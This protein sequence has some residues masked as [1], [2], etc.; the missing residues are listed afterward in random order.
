MFHSF[1]TLSRILG[2]GAWCHHV[3]KIQEKAFGEKRLLGEKVASL[4]DTF[5]QGEPT[6]SLSSG[7]FNR[8]D[9]VTFSIVQATAKIRVYRRLGCTVI[10][11]KDVVQL[12]APIR[13]ATTNPST[14]GRRP[15]GSSARNISIPT[16]ED[17]PG[18][19]GDYGAHSAAQG[20]GFVPTR[21][22]SA[23]ALSL[24]APAPPWRHSGAPPAAVSRQVDSIQDTRKRRFSDRDD[25]DSSIIPVAARSAIE[26][27]DENDN[28]SGFLGSTNYEVLQLKTRVNNLVAQNHELS[29]ANMKLRH[30]GMR[31]IRDFQAKLKRVEDHNRMYVQ[32]LQQMETLLAQQQQIISLQSQQSQNEPD[33]LDELR[34]LDQQFGGSL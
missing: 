8:I 33:P 14:R 3:Y 15:A 11:G 32:R 29:Q 27:A 7:D 25:G 28:A 1:I 23:R 26:V 31:A 5:P 19:K 24:R 22:R 9:N 2:I 18:D 12:E 17:D 4:A 30:D 6:F 21:G 13:Q 10:R 20:F 16:E 34:H